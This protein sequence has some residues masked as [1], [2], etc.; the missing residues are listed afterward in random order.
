MRGSHAYRRAMRAFRDEQR[1]AAGNSD[2]EAPDE[3]PRPLVQHVRRESNTGN[4]LPVGPL[5]GWMRSVGGAMTQLVYNAFSRQDVRRKMWKGF[6]GLFDILQRPAPRALMPVGAEAK[7][8]DA[9]ARHFSND[10]MVVAAAVHWADRAWVASLCSHLSQLQMDGK[11]RLIAR[12]RWRS[13][14]STPLKLAAWK[15]FRGPESPEFMQYALRDSTAR[16]ATSLLGGRTE[17]QIVKVLQ[18]EYVL[19]FLVQSVQDGRY[20]LINSPM[21]CPL[22][23]TDS[24]TA[25]AL[26]HM[27]AEQMFVPQMDSLSKQFKYRIELSTCD[28]GSANLKFEAIAAHAAMPG[29]MYLR[30]GCEIHNLSRVQVRTFDIVAPVL[31]GAI[32]LALAC[33]GGGKTQALRLVLVDILKAHL[34][35]MLDRRF[36]TVLP[37]SSRLC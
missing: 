24:E 4:V 30:Q 25:E 36:S 2:N 29:S 21:S 11:I 13:Y 28:S 35:C 8:L 12:M 19:G 16:T 37:R 32:A 27:H 1:D 17:T 26:H 34:Q 22:Q 10:V 9:S 6:Q 18:S 20:M 3:P 5:M 14:D 33:K 23:A 7:L 31:S 15:A